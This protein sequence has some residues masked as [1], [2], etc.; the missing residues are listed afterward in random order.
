M[1]NLLHLVLMK[2]ALLQL[3]LE[4]VMSWLELGNVHPLAVNIMLVNVTAINGNTL[5]SVIG[6][7]VSKITTTFQIIN[8]IKD[9]SHIFT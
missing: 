5:I 3:Y 4:C 2:V 8:F 9:L 1:G 6:A 7:F